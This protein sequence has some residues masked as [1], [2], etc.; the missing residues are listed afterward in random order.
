VGS[1]KDCPWASPT[2]VLFACEKLAAE[3]PSHAPTPVVGGVVEAVS[4]PN[5][6]GA[7]SA[8]KLAASKV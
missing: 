7:L 4:G 2:N 8:K 5:G 6:L 3:L 1:W